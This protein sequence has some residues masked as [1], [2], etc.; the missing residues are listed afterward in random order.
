M[1]YQRTRGTD[2]CCNIAIY[3]Y[4]PEK[5]G[6]AAARDLAGFAQEPAIRRTSEGFVG[7]NAVLGAGL[8]LWWRAGAL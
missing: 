5:C 7:P 8:G 4:C 2:Y 1:V 3:T 6:Q